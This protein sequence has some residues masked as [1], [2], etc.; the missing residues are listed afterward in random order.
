[1]TV[2]YF[3]EK[4]VYGA[5]P[6]APGRPLDPV[7]FYVG[8]FIW[9]SGYGTAYSMKM[10]SSQPKIIDN[11]KGLLISFN[12]IGAQWNNQTVSPSL[13]V[14]I[15]DLPPFTTAC[16]RWLMIC[17]LSGDF[18]DYAATFQ[19]SNPIGRSDL[20]LIDNVTIYQLIHSVV[21]DEPSND[22]I[23]DFLTNEILNP[24]Y[25]PDHV[26]SSYQNEEFLVYAVTN[27][28]IISNITN[29][30]GTTIVV[31]YLPITNF[32][33]VTY[34][35]GRITDE[36]ISMSLTSVIRIYDG[37]QIIMGDNVWRTSRSTYLLN[38]ATI[39]QNF[40]HLFDYYSNT[41]GVN[42]LQYS[43]TFNG[44]LPPENFH[45]FDVNFSSVSLAWNHSNP[46]VTTYKLQMRL[47][48]NANANWTVLQ[49]FLVA[50][51]YVVNGLQPNTEYEFQV[52][53]SLNGYFELTGASITVQTLVASI[54]GTIA[55]SSSATPEVTTTIIG[56][57]KQSSGVSTTIVVI[58]V[59]LVILFLVIV[60]IIILVWYLH[61]RQSKRKDWTND[62][63]N[64][65]DIVHQPKEK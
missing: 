55:I 44:L 9:N 4:Y 17:S 36:F 29:A 16:V 8:L 42:N 58:I 63:I 34:F 48:N 46:N 20:S 25:L 19:N 51:Q 10:S 61:R 49:N 33:N 53:A 23:P 2:K 22:G 45:A 7:P 37:K 64:L 6:F 5:D 11:Q 27:Y 60:G 15:G 54:T 39:Y 59:V 50:N 41:T 28:T 3:W 56:A 18:I 14:D 12:L 40:I 65:A 1:M 26:H 52:F 24:M 47:A 21:I 32:P 13:L 30:A 57:V 35:Y 38:N 43:L 31:K 62:D